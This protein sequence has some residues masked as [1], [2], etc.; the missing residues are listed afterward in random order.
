MSP[1]VIFVAGLDRD[2]RLTAARVLA[3]EGQAPMLDID[4][5]TGPL[6]RHIVGNATGDPDDRTGTLYRTVVEPMQYQTLLQ[7]VWAQVEAGVPLIVATAPFTR[8]LDQPEW[9]HGVS[10][11][12]AL[13]GY[14][15]VIVYCLNDGET[16]PV[17]DPEHYILPAP[18]SVEAQFTTLTH[19][20]IELR[21]SAAR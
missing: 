11:D 3:G 8:Q 12:L 13:H 5:L 19:L 1:T 9:L 16:A 6:T 21:S 4:D 15:A 14:D 2:D 20:A 17:L 18:A 7:A 10:Y